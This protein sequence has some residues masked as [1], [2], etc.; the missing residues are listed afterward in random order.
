MMNKVTVTTHPN[1]ALIKYW[2]KRNEQLFLPTK[3]S[4]SIGIQALSTTTSIHY[5]NTG[6]EQIIINGEPADEKHRQPILDFLRF[7]RTD[8]NI[9]TINPDKL[10]EP[11]TIETTNSFPTAAGLASSASGFAALAIAL[12]NFFNLGLTQKELSQLA[13]QGS[14]SACRSLFDGFVLWNKGE[15]EDGSD[16]QAEQLFDAN[17]WPS[18]RVMIV[19]VEQEAKKISSR[20]AMKNSIATSPIY[21]Q[22]VQES[23]YRI[24]PMRQAIAEKNFDLMGQLAEQD[25]LGMHATMHTSTPAV[26]FWTPATQ[27]IMHLVTTLREQHAIPCYFTIDAGPNVKILC[28]EENMQKIREHLA[29]L[30]EI[31]QIIESSIA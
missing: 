25:C 4:L 24:A 30:P 27:R 11:L 20:A 15:K 8:A 17:H 14:G 6:Q 10:N 31:I 7:F 16:S 12:N 13:R 1:I 5:S 23:E 18:L 22:W 21:S 26:N 9:T 3:S 28:Q 29:S 2:G 19:V